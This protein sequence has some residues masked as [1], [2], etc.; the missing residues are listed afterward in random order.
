MCIRDSAWIVREVDDSTESVIGLEHTDALTGLGNRRALEA[1]L[2]LRSGDDAHAMV[3]VVDVDDF[4][5]VNHAVGHSGGDAVLIVI[6]SRVRAAARPED[7]VARIGTDQFA[8]YSR[9]ADAATATAVAERIQAQVFA[10]D[11]VAGLSVGAQITK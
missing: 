2:A 3:L 7:L 1:A 10:E 9:G 8:V 4:V 5:G 11:E 6:A